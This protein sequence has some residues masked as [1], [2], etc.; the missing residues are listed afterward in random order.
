M[1]IETSIDIETLSTKHNAVILSLGAVKF[2]LTDEDTL[3]SIAPERCFYRVFDT[4][5]QIDR[6]RHIDSDTLKWWLQQAPEA[7]EAALSKPQ[8]VHTVLRELSEWLTPGTNLWGNG[9]TFDNILLRSL[10]HDYHMPY[11]VKYYQDLDLRTLRY[12]AGVRGK[13]SDPLEH[14]ALTDAKQQAV[15]AQSYYQL[16]QLR[17]AA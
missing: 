7:L 15:E 1:F 9:N 2:N 13:R 3:A 4:I 12:A 11:P 10:Y 17:T 14:H 16:I 8:P 5:T 6:G